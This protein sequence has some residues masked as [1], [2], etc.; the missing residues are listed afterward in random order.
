MPIVRKSNYTCIDKSVSIRLMGELVTSSNNT[1]KW[2]ELDNLYSP[3]E[4]VK[5]RLDLLVD[6]NWLV[7]RN[8]KYLCLPKI[9][10]LVKINILFQKLYRLD[11]T[12]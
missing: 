10:T 12:G 6:K 8:D 3:I 9:E 4:M 1:L 7:M 5:P 11:K 2:E